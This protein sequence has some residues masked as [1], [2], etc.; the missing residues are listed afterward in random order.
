MV[1]YDEY[2]KG[3]MEKI[4]GSHDK[5][6]SL[7]DRP[8]DLEATRIE[9]LKIKGFFQVLAHKIDAARYP[10]LDVGRLQ[11]KAESYLETYYFDREIENVSSLYA[12]DPGRV[13]NLR[14][15]ILGSLNDRGLMEYIAETAGEM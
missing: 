4:I 1:T 6:E 12:D 13:R 14:L 10:S 9:L 3:I 7:G 5:I 11:A 8:A 2:L 15:A